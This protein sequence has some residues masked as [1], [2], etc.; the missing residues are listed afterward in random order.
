MAP[1]RLHV[2]SESSGEYDADERRPT[3]GEVAGGIRHVRIP[4]NVFDCPYLSHGAIRLYGRLQQHAGADGCFPS[5]ETLATR[6]GCSERAV[7]EYRQELEDAGVIVHKRGGGARSNR[8]ELTPDRLRDMSAESTHIRKSAKSADIGDKTAKS[9]VESRQ[10]LPPMS[11]KSAEE[12]YLSNQTSLTRDSAPTERAAP[13][14]KPAAKPAV[15]TPKQPAPTVNA[16]PPEREH[17]PRAKLASAEDTPPSAL[18]EPTPI[19][20]VEQGIK[21]A[22]VK[23]A[24]SWGPDGKALATLLAGSD[25]TTEDVIGC[26]V[27]IARGEYGDQYAREHLSVLYVC[28]RCINGYLNWRQNPALPVRAR[29]NGNA[30]TGGLSLADLVS[31]GKGERQL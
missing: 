23:V 26:Y 14:S 31:I 15:R 16:T 30:P 12:S 4:V 25:V 19:Q 13:P 8:Y 27:A 22:G 7:R 2:V 5:Y 17:V 11:A 29:S 20:R 9:A 24:V 10:N 18:R 1:Y 3:P 28:T 21:A 6:M